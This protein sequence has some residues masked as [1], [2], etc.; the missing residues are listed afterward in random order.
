[1]GE[2]TRIEWA[3]ATVN[4]TSG[5]DKV[6]AGC[7][8]CYAER[9]WPRLSAPGQPY[10]GRKFTDIKLHPERLKDLGRG[11]GKRIFIN[12]MSDLFHEAVPDEF[13][14]QVCATC[15]LHP[16]NDYLILTKRAE[17]QREY[18]TEKDIKTRIANQMYART[19][20][21]PCF[22]ADA[23]QD[24]HAPWITLWPLPNVIGMVSVE[25]QKTADERIPELL[26]TP[27]AV[28][29]VSYEPGLAGVDFGRWLGGGNALPEYTPHR[30]RR[31]LDWIIVGGESGP[32]ARPFDIEWARKT[33]GDCRAAG[34]PV[35]VK[36]DSG[37]R[38][39]QRGR[40]PLSLWI[41][42]F[43]KVALRAKAD[44]MEE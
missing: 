42:E 5:C 19:N 21:V 22:A 36:Q 27:W 13:I 1:M 2:K 15:A 23:G 37:P 29:G 28:R 35:F 10:A 8:N 3:D 34:V 12:S 11:R 25:D 20:V 24:R 43:P 17:R 16:E 14:D 33:I 38:P 41:K 39:G 44:Q 9:T 32:G 7:K 6:S 31:G 4:V 26:A 18:L 40:I 30:P